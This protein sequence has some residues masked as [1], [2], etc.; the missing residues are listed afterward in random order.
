MKAFIFFGFIYTFMF[1]MGCGEV[2]D[3]DGNSASANQNGQNGW[4]IPRDQVFNGGP[5]KDGI[6]A[7]TEPVFIS[8][9]SADYLDEDDLVMGFVHGDDARAYPHSILDW[10]E[11]INDRIGE[12]DIAVT[13]CPLTGTG[14][15]WNREIGGQVTTFGVSGLLFNS[16]LIPY[17]RETDSNWSQIRLDCVQGKLKGRQVETI[18]MLETTWRTWKQMYPETKVISE[19]TGYNR[20]YGQYPYGNYRSDHDMMLFPVANR[21]DRIPGK[22]RVLGIIGP[23]D[24]R[25]YRFEAFGDKV[26]VLHDTLGGKHVVITGNQK[27]HF[28]LAFINDPGDGTR[29]SFSA[30]QDS[31]PVVISDE[32]GNM[33][34]VHGRA[35]AGP[36]KNERLEILPSFMGYWFSFAAFYPELSI[37][38]S[39]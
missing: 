18:P 8:A 24:V 12:A 3:N 14:I 29:L 20:N 35:V 11:I 5:G 16:N 26:A 23:E 33:W 32:E 31:Y 10:H 25:V 38:G 2:F 37:Y 19:H 13:Y 7:L 6:P 15:G 28:M 34:D 39:S 22:E 36:R 4:A 27:D 21:D 1:P 9:R 17:D 30:V